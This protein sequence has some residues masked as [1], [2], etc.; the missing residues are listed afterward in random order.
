M[1][2]LQKQSDMKDKKLEKLKLERKEVLRHYDILLTPQEENRLFNELQRIHT[3]I[4]LITN[5]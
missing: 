4:K 1:E 5:N 3:E 2:A